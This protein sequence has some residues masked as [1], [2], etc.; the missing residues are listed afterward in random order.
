MNRKYSCG[1]CGVPDKI[2]N[3]HIDC[4]ADVWHA[5]LKSMELLNIELVMDWAKGQDEL[6]KA[7]SVIVKKAL[8]EIDKLKLAEDE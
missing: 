3:P 1:K 8:E 6:H 5:A 7:K 4:V 2:C